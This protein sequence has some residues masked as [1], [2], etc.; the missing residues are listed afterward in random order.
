MLNH[1]GKET[2]STLQNT[3]LAKRDANS[4]LAFLS[5]VMA[6][7]NAVVNIISSVNSNNNNNNNNN[8]NDNNN[9][10]MNMN[11]NEVMSM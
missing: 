2:S 4:Q 5:F 7:L 10:N 1:H 11:M 3:R 8:N 6:L 9:N